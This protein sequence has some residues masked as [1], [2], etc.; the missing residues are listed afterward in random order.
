MSTIT[1][2]YLS[3][4]YPFKFFKGCLP[5]I[6]LGPLLNILAHLL[7][8]IGTCSFHTIDGAFKYRAEKS[9]W[10]LK[11]NIQGCYILLYDSPARRDDCHSITGSEKFSLQLC[12]KR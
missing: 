11:K 3:R 9:D 8:D 1:L 4:P 12:S 7:V 6:L 5:Q 10:N 2:H